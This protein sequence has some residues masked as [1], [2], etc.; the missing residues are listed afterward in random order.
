VAGR[1][2][3]PHDSLFAGVRFV[4]VERVGNDVGYAVWVRHSS[5]RECGAP[6]A[7]EP[8]GPGPPDWRTP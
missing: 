8:G 2:P 5:R 7:P 3:D 6:A 1:G 4:V